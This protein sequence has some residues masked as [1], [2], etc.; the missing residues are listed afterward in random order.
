M[1]FPCMGFQQVLQFHT[2]FKGHTGKITGTNMYVQIGIIIQSQHMIGQRDHMLALT[3]Q[4][5]SDPSLWK[6]EE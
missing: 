6:E 3:N 2:T 4:N 5:C 1:F